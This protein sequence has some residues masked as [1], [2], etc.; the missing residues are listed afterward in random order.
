ME[1]SKEGPLEV[2]YVIWIVC[3]QQTN[4]TIQCKISTIIAPESNEWRL[5]PF[6]NP[7]DFPI[8][9]MAFWNDYDF[10]SSYHELLGPGPE[11]PG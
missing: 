6:R 4:L 5:I 11:G 3:F 2:T 9:E 8:A 7:M 1:F 10:K